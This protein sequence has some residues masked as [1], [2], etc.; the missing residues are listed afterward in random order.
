MG[1]ED[2][3]MSMMTIFMEES[4]RRDEENRRRD[5]ENRRR[6]EENRRR[7]EERG[8]IS[9]APSVDSTSD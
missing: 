4:R 7:A 3:F 9:A 5:E 6:D 8:K 1:S 2:K